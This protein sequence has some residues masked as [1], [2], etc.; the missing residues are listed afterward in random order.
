MKSG[1]QRRQEIL[2][3]RKLRSLIHKRMSFA[4]WLEPDQIPRGAILAEPSRLLHDN[5]Y[6][7]RPRFYADRSFTCIDCGVDE[8][9]TAA[10]QKWWYEVAQGKIDSKANRCRQCRYRRRMR[11]AQSRRIHIEGVIAKYG[12][13][14]AA[15]QLQITIEALDLMRARWNGD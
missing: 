5:T 14:T 9:W 7:P 10:Q 3:R 15:R 12:I 1:R 13:K 6:G 4:P 8:V 2:E 11:S